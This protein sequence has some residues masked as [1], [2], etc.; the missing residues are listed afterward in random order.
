MGLCLALLLL[1]LLSRCHAFFIVI[2]ARQRSG[3]TELAYRLGQHPCV[4]DL[5]EFFNDP[6][7]KDAPL[8]ANTHYRWELYNYLSQHP[9]FVEQEPLLPS[10]R[11]QAVAALRVARAVMCAEKDRQL[12][13]HGESVCAER[14]S[15]VVKLFDG[16]LATV[17]GVADLVAQPETL[18]VV[19]ERNALDRMCSLAWAKANNDW[20]H[21]PHGTPL[22]ECRKGFKR[23]G[24]AVRIERHNNAWFETVRRSAAKARKIA[25]ELPFEA[26]TDA[27]Q[28][29]AVLRALWALAD[30]PP[31]RSTAVGA[32]YVGPYEGS[33]V[34][35]NI[36]QLMR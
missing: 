17:R 31:N 13:Q 20:R 10:R 35:G 24:T 11:T 12:A 3:S 19:L 2:A 15:I 28:S 27:K 8:A 9:A 7:Q 21:S 34:E 29:P 1:S 4:V 18:L 25:F 32:R 26:W 22:A 16:H 33:G 14:C 6:G 5:Q 30:L 23:N 36:S